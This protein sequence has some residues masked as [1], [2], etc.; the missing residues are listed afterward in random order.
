MGVYHASWMVDSK[1][2]VW[3]PPQSSQLTRQQ[4][5]VMGGLS[6]VSIKDIKPRIIENLINYAD[7]VCLGIK[8]F[9]DPY[10]DAKN[11]TLISI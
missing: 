3:C 2:K 9:G 5:G 11:E 10:G 7:L 1:K 6:K 4:L 8:D